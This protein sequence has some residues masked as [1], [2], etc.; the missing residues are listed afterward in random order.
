MI[1][2]EFVLNGRAVD[3][4]LYFQQLVRVHGILRQAFPALVNRNRVLLQSD[5]ARPR[6][7][8]TTMTKIQELREIELLP[9][10]AYRRDL[11]PSD[12]HLF[13]FMVHFLRVRNFENI[14]AV[15]VG[16][17]EFFASKTRDWYRRGIMNL[18]ET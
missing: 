11:A 16:L 9:H 17:T 14:E 13:R 1:H 3:A 2:W 8:G 7:A 12:Y 15:E 6:T 5:N 18:A 4:F 10:P